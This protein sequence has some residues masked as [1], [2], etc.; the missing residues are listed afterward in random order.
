MKALYFILIIFGVGS[1]FMNMDSAESA[2]QQCVVV[3]IALFWLMLAR[4]AQA[5]F[6]GNSMTGGSFKDLFVRRDKPE[7][8]LN[9]PL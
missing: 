2:P 8:T 9:K 4:I 1:Y 6:F 7:D 3:G 5:E